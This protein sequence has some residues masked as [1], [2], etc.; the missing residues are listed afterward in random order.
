[1]SVATDEHLIVHVP[2]HAERALEL[3]YRQHKG[4]PRIEALVRALAAGAQLL[5]N[6]T[7]AV[8][9]GG[10]LD[11]AEGETL[12]RWGE[13]VGEIQGG[14]THEQYRTFI[15]LRARVNTLFPN[16]DMMWALLDEAL[17]PFQEVTRYLVSDGI[18]WGVEVPEMPGQPVLDHTAGLIRDARPIGIYSPVVVWTPS[19]FGW[20]S[21]I[22]GDD[23]FAELIYDGRTRSTT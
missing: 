18:V 19:S 22:G 16:E 4:K 10:S 2:N 11:A 3:L 13:L 21:E 15:A 8:I 12:T 23:P 9:A 6:T 20:E 14:L 7:W 1:M 17:A 5:E